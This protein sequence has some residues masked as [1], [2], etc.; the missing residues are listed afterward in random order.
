M[1][2]MLKRQIQHGSCIQEPLE[3]FFLLYLYSP[4]THTA[5]N[6]IILNI[7]EEYTTKRRVLTSISD[8]AVRKTQS[9]FTR[10]LS[11][12]NKSRQ[13]NPETILLK[14]TKS[15]I[16]EQIIGMVDYWRRQPTKKHQ[17]YMDQH[18][19]DQSI[20]PLICVNSTGSSVHT[21]ITKDSTQETKQISKTYIWNQTGTTNIQLASPY[22]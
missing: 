1:Q 11:L 5:R 16:K 3:M 15:Q 13:H 18:I 14:W 6:S 8:I 9:Q 19:T 22:N 12:Q 20:A 7:W 21:N 10:R 4:P 2:M 17:R